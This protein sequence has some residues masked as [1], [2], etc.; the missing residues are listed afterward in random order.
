MRRRNL[1]AGLVVFWIKLRQRGYSRSITGLFRLLR[2]LKLT[3]VKPRNP[4]YIPKPY[5][6]MMYPEQRV[7]IDVKF[8]PSACIVG[9]AKGKKFYQYTAID[10]FSRFRYIEAFEEHSTYCSAL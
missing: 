7:Q 3:P 6:Q 9:D 5:E 8:V 10:E 4:K 2:R 1:H